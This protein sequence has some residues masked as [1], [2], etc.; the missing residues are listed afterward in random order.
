MV[1]SYLQT[2]VEENFLFGFNLNKQRTQE[3]QGKTQWRRRLS[4]FQNMILLT[5][6]SSGKQSQNATKNNISEATVTHTSSNKNENG[7][8]LKAKQF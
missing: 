8:M 4:F 2:K 6:Q 5:K 3:T 7:K 1:K